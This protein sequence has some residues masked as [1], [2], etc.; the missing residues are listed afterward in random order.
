VAT[1]AVREKASQAEE[2]TSA[3]WNCR[4]RKASRSLPDMRLAISWS[5]SRSDTSMLELGIGDAAI[6][7]TGDPRRP[8]LVVHEGD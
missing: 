5:V 6:P 3:Q 7:A 1:D 8:R 2:G 4:R